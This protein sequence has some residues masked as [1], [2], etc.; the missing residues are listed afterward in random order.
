MMRA[1]LGT[2]VKLPSSWLLLLSVVNAAVVVLIMRGLPIDVSIIW[3][4]QKNGLGAQNTRSVSLVPPTSRFVLLSLA[5]D[6]LACATVHIQFSIAFAALTRRSAVLPAGGVVRSQRSSSHLPRLSTMF[7][8]VWDKEHLKRFV[9]GNVVD[10]VEMQARV[11]QPA[12]VAVLRVMLNHAPV[13]VRGD[14]V[15]PNALNCSRVGDMRDVLVCDCPEEDSAGQLW[16]PSTDASSGWMLENNS[17]QRLREV[18]VFV[19]SPSLFWMSNRTELLLA[20]EQLRAFDWSIRAC[21]GTDRGCDVLAR[22]YENASQ[23]YF[24]GLSWM[25]SVDESWLQ[26]VDI[27]LLHLQR[28]VVLPSAKVFSSEMLFR[29]DPLI[30]SCVHELRPAQR[31]GL[32]V[33]F[34]TGRVY[35][36]ARDASAFCRVFGVLND[37]CL[38]IPVYERLQLIV[39]D[40]VSFVEQQVLLHRDAKVMFATDWPVASRLPESVTPRG[41]ARWVGQVLGTDFVDADRESVLVL[42]NAV[43]RLAGMQSSEVRESRHRS[44]LCAQVVDALGNGTMSVLEDLV[45]LKESPRVLMFSAVM[46]TCWKRFMMDGLTLQTLSNSSLFAFFE[47]DNTNG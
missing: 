5:P 40:L 19:P 20:R 42:S 46:H 1:C 45:L 30:L 9:Y 8:R 32:A 15:L 31:S 27:V 10:G 47:R 33:H 7:D 34:R 28:G 16:M 25:Q 6:R 26:D 18:C 17:S 11:K 35:G 21:L 24:L 41:W 38:A 4:D 44:A 37:T 43:E 36:F 12:T 13:L 22:L 2:S 29:I 39:D 23:P 14:W 3:K